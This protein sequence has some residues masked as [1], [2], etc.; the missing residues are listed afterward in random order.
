MILTEMSTTTTTTT[1]TTNQCRK[2]C[3]LFGCYSVSFNH[4]FDSI[5]ICIK[6]EKKKLID[7][8]LVETTTLVCML[9]QYVIVII[10]N[11]D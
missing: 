9:S 11:T 1:T 2:Y 5:G 4:L 3:L 8:L 6:R 10:E 7:V